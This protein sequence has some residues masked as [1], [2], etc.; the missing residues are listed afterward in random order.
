M[1]VGDS[2]GDED[3]VGIPRGGDGVGDGHIDDLGGGGGE[4]VIAA[5]AHMVS[6]GAGGCDGGGGEEGEEGEAGG[7]HFAGLVWVEV[8]KKSERVEL[9]RYIATNLNSQKPKGVTVLCKKAVIE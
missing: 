8:L 4:L 3:S 1:D 2:W 7:D 6:V 5:D 9:K